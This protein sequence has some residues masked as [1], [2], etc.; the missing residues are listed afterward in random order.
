MP[1][2]AHFSVWQTQTGSTTRWM[3]TLDQGIDAS[4]RNYY[5]SGGHTHYNFGF[6]QPG[7]YEIDYQI[8]TFVNLN[9]TPGDTDVDGDVDFSD[10]LT[11]AQN[12][13]TTRGMWWQRGDFQADGA[14]GFDDLLALAQNYGSGALLSSEELF[15]GQTLINALVPEP[16][17]LLTLTA[18]GLLLRRLGR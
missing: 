14:V 11:L 18:S 2:G 10:L 9:W 12:Y 15:A 16:S 7:L 17:A 4:D 8:R 3:S 5:T 13:G 6:T 1:E